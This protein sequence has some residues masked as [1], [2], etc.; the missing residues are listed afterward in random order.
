MFQYTHLLIWPFV[1]LLLA[2][3]SGALIEPPVLGYWLI[4]PMLCV[5]WDRIPRTALMFRP[6]KGATFEAIEDSTVMVT[7]PE[8]SVDW[9]YK[10]GQYIL[11]RV[12]EVSYFEWHPFSVVGSTQPD[13]IAGRVYIRNVGDWTGALL[14]R[15]SAGLPMTLTVDGP[16]GSP[17]AQMGMFERIVIVG[18]GIGVT[19]YAG[20]LHDLRPEQS[21]D[22]H[23]VVREQISF[24]WF[25]TLLNTFALKVEAATPRATVTVRTYATGLQPRSTAQYV[26]RV[27]L[28]K[29]RTVTHPTSYVTGLEVETKYGR[30][31]IALIFHSAAQGKEESD[32]R[33]EEGGRRSRGR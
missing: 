16:F 7:I 8:S 12:Q 20:W 17:A 10:P 23:W 31:D 19:P 24:T 28:E 2:H 29:H 27:L 1:G 4:V 32:G 15:T 21:V 6:I 14:K 26:L 30:P 25:S 18:T 13:G 33:K 11:V 9:T 22:F 5:L 3:G